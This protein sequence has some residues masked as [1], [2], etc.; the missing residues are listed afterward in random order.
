M[1]RFKLLGGK[2]YEDRLP[3]HMAADFRWLRIRFQTRF[4]KKAYPH[5]NLT[6]THPDSPG[7]GAKSDPTS[8]MEPE[9][10]A[11]LNRVLKNPE[12]SSTCSGRNLFLV[13]LTF[14][15]SGRIARLRFE[16]SAADSGYA[17]WGALFWGEPTASPPTHLSGISQSAE[18][19]MRPNPGP[20]RSNP[21]N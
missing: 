17:I 7:G 12:S 20:T 9:Q 15:P 14:C 3:P 1:P 11:S 4:V 10:K 6:L 13:G 19:T 2:A 18:T 8:C 5:K 21:W 16:S